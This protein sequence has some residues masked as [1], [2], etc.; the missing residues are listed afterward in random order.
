MAVIATTDG[1]RTGDCGPQYRRRP[2]GKMHKTRKVRSH[3]RAVTLSFALLTGAVAQPA[4]AQADPND[5]YFL[6]DLIDMGVSVVP[7]NARLLT[8]YGQT[9]CHMLDE[10]NDVLAIDNRL[11]KDGTLNANARS[12]IAAAATREYCPWNR[13]RF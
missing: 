10:G 9:V 13:G 6:A 11:K 4:S 12:A 5:R 2:A 3:F 8:T 7:D 1:P